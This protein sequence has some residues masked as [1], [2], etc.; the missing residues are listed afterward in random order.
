MRK[1][2]TLALAFSSP[3]PRPTR[4]SPRSRRAASSECSRCWNPNRPEFFSTAPDREPGFDYEIVRG[5][6]RLYKLELVV[7]PD[8]GVG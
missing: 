5:F 2:A 7:R 1:L 8:R 4:I 3:R 6:A